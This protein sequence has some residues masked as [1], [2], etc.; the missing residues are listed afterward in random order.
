MAKIIDITETLHFEEKPII[1]VKDEMLT[2]NNE[3]VVIL[4]ILPMLDDNAPASDLL[5]ACK[6]LFGDEGYEKIKALRLDIDDFKAFLESAIKL[7]TGD[8]EGEVLTRA[9]T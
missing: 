7:V 1:K 3:A 9:T 2:V 6:M 4:E 5:K 8:T